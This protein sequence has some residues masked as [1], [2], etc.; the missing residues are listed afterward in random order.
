MCDLTELTLHGFVARARND[1]DAAFLSSLHRDVQ[2]AIEAAMHNHKAFL[3][4]FS[5]LNRD[6]E[7][8]ITLAVMRGDDCE[9]GRM[10]AKALRREVARFASEKEKDEIADNFGVD[11]DTEDAK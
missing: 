8:E 10:L 4:A 11:L 1:S 2:L 6:E 5:N 3:S 9:A 7:A